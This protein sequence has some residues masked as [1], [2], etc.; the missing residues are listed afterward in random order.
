[1]TREYE[2]IRSLD[3][4]RLPRLRGRKEKCDNPKNVICYVDIFAVHDPIQQ[5]KK[6][7]AKQETEAA[8]REK[9]DTRT[10]EYCKC[11]DQ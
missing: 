5:R 1:M 6:G 2:F 7:Q 11:L 3:T 9:C 8:G 10:S 4:R